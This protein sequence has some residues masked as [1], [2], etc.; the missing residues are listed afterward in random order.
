MK[1]QDS[2]ELK[3]Q[4]LD[5]LLNWYE[6]TKIEDEIEIKKTK[7]DFIKEIKK[8]NKIDIKNTTPEL[9]KNVSLWMRIKKTLG[10][11]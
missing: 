5:R 2:K 11:G 10:I 8:F 6:K 7:Q 1:H 4:Y 9:P 3:N